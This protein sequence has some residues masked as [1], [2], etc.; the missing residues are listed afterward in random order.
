MYILEDL[1]DFSVQILTNF[2][3]RAEI[4]LKNCYFHKRRKSWLR[5]LASPSPSQNYFEMV[6]MK[7]FATSRIK[8]R[9]GACLMLESNLLHWTG[10]LR[11]PS[12][13]WRSWWRDPSWIES[14]PTIPFEEDWAIVM[15][16]SSKPSPTKG[17]YER[18]CATH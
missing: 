7:L 10:N 9:I 4:Y 3:F 5:I 14:P 15:T 8:F 2:D 6:K 18:L 12:T 11:V 13:G 17:E 16:N 1:Q